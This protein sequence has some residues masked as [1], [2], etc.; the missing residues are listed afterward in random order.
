MSLLI[1]LRTML[2]N[3]AGDFL[4][5]ELQ[6]VDDHYPLYG[7]LQLDPEQ[8]RQPPRSNG[9][10]AGVWRWIRC[11]HSGWTWPREMRWRSGR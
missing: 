2:G 11:W 4:L 5:V 1:E 9:T 8:D 3:P 6:S 10:D 7:E